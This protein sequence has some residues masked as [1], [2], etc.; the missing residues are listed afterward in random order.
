M[1]TFGLSHRKYQFGTTLIEVLVSLVII[2]IGLLGLAGL[3]MKIHLGLVESFQRA[4]AIVLLSDMSERIQ[5]DRSVAAQY[6]L[7]GALGTGDAQPADCRTIPAGYQRDQ[8]EWSNAL[9]GAAETKGGSN[10]GAMLDARGCIAQVQAPD[11]TPG[12]CQPGIYLV[13]VA[14]QGENPTRA[15]AAGLSCGQGLYKDMSGAVNDAYRRAISERV[16]IGLPSC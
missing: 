5:A 6:V 2:A 16:S 1:L 3:Q 12:I 7:P 15:P 8:C 4:Q 10:T 14:W 13:T 11:P 9:K